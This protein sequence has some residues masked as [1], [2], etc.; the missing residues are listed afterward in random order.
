MNIALYLRLSMADGDLGQDKKDES[1]SIENQRLLL[2]S[3]LDEKEGLYDPE[4][5]TVAEFVDDGYTG[6]NFDRPSFQRMIEEAKKGKVDIILVKDLSRL[7]RDYITVGDYMEQIF[8]LLGVRLIAV[9]NKYD[10]GET[11]IPSLDLELSNLVNTLYSRDLSK[12]IRT[13]KRAKMRSGSYKPIRVPYGYRKKPGTGGEAWEIDPEAAKV[14]RF[15]F[16]EALKGHDTPAIAA[17]LNRRSVPTRME[18]EREKG[19]AYSRKLITTEHER[20]WNCSMI[21]CVL[22]CYE[23]TGAMI[24][25]KKESLTVGSG[26]TRKTEPHKWIIRENDHA[27]IVSKEDFEK[28]QSMLR[29]RKMPDYTLQHRYSLK[30]KVRCGNCNKKLV[31]RVNTYDEF[32]LCIHG[33]AQG[34]FS[35]CC[36]D[37]YSVKWLEDLVLRSLEGLFGQIIFLQEK[38]HRE[39]KKCAAA[40]LESRITQLKNSRLNLYELYAGQIMTRKEYLEKKKKIQ[41]EMD[42]LEEEQ[43]KA[44]KA[45]EDQSKM[46]AAVDK[47]AEDAKLFTGKLTDEIVERFIDTVYVYDSERIEIVYKLEDVIKKELML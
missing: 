20:L 41:E 3:Y 22:D 17:S 5:D 47:T 1:N 31:Y 19:T 34:E 12:K 46:T 27:P 23:Y 39:S 45:E 21:R 25:G 24:G 33:R 44:R 36:K 16:A 35:A 30:G 37:Q 18:Y 7:G 14:V 42:S 32:Y 43:Q 40:A 13:G 9:N 15:I 8:P 38:A 29:S 26:R 28:V 11:S 10:S 6:T 4:K 2:R